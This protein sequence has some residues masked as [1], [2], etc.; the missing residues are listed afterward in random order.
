MPRYIAGTEVYTHS[1]AKLQ[2]DAG[3]Q[4][5][6]ITPHIEHYAPGK[7]QDYYQYDG[8]D[9]YQFLETANPA[10]REFYSGNRKPLGLNNFFEL[11][12]KLQPDVVHFHELNRS[13]GITIEHLKLAR[14]IASK[15]FITMHLSFYTCNTNRLVKKNKLCSGQI[16]ELDCSACTYNSIYKFPNLLAALMA[17]FS[18]VMNRTGISS[19]LMP[20]KF[21]TLVAMPSTIQR[22]KNELKELVENVD[23]I[24]SLTEFYK[25]ILILNGVPEKKITFIPQALANVVGKN[26]TPTQF[27]KSETLRLVFIGRIQPQKGLHLIIEAFKSFSETELSIDIYGKPEDSA[28]Y[29][30]CIADSERMTNINWKG[31]IEG[32]KVVSMLSGFDFLCLPSLFSEM[33]PLVIQ[34]AFA[35]GIP[36][37]ASKVY[38]NMEQI[39]HK[40]NGLL[41]EFNS[42]SDLVVQL[43]KLIAQPELIGKMKQQI[44]LPKTFD[45]VYKSYMQL[46]QS[47]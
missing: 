27:I 31:L 20:G 29:K 3:H 7:I 33:S 9:V 36:V 43:K 1:L 8:I 11:I 39:E 12:K 4:V 17:N 23:Q 16:I 38:G 44:Q 22:I 34:E 37:L 2:Q 19:R 24:I 40:K 15:I 14:Q 46:Y 32:N 45:E 6:I 25:K 41:F 30:K 26:V 10:N 42:A 47:N 5:S 35:A 21:T 13:I 18:V 28:Y